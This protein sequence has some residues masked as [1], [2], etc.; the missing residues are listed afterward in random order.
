MKISCLLLVGGTSVEQ[1]KIDIREKK[2]QII[3]GTPEEFTILF[4]EELSI[5]KK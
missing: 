3:V 1:N 5:P 4:V 2:P